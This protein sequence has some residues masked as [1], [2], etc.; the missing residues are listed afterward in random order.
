M[1]AC[2]RLSDS[3]GVALEPNRLSTP[4]KAKPNRA[5]PQRGKT[6]GHPGFTPAALPGTPASRQPWH[7][8]KGFCAENHRWSWP[9]TGRPRI[10]KLLQ[11]GLHI[12]MEESRSG[13]P[14]RRMRNDEQRRSC[15]LPQRAKIDDAVT[16]VPGKV[17]CKLLAH[18]V[19]AEAEVFRALM[20]GARFP[21]GRERAVRYSLSPASVRSRTRPDAT[22][23]S[24][25]RRAMISARLRSILRPKPAPFAPVGGRGS[26]SGVGRCFA[27][28]QGSIRDLHVLFVPTGSR[29]Q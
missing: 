25:S 23:G 24:S 9:E 11:I 16:A 8:D 28:Q 12:R 22:T 17:T 18:V 6:N 27:A 2:E 1:T 13:L 3:F 4:A 5:V 7:H 10:E 26:K 14:G 19:E 29:N 20:K 21:G 15:S